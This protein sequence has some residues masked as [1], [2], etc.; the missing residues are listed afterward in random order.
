MFQHLAANNIL[1]GI[2]LNAVEL[3]LQGSMAFY[4][5]SVSMAIFW[6]QY[7]II[8]GDIDPNDD[9]PV[10]FG[11]DRK[12]RIQDLSPFEARNMTRFTKPQLVRIFNLLRIPAI[13]HVGLGTSTY[14]MTGEEI[15]LFSLTKMAH[16]L[17]NV[18]LCSTYFGGSGKRWSYAYPWFLFFIDDS[19]GH[20][21]GFEGLQ[22]FVIHFPYFARKIAE[23]LNKPRKYVNPF[24]GVTTTVPGLNLDPFLF[25]IF[26]FVDG[27]YFRSCTPG[28]GPDGDFEGAPRKV[29]SYLIQRAFYTG[30]KK[31]HG[32][33]IMSIMLPNGLHFIY[34]PVSARL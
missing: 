12:R 20:V 23:K 8:L 4:T 30:Y 16:G 24:T 26:G 22:R 18:Q 19:F 13:V 33:A 14:E 21:L 15:F 10:D 28:T 11:P 2:D 32:L 6:R 31:I 9:D 27:S 3:A 7:D 29:D 5:S 1:P 34:G 17:D 25:R